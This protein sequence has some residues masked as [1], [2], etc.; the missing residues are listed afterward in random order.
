MNELSS[1]DGRHTAPHSDNSIVRTAPVETVDTANE[2]TRIII[3]PHEGDDP[4]DLSPQPTDTPSPVQ[5]PIQPPTYASDIPS[6]IPAEAYDADDIGPAAGHT[7]KEKTNLIDFSRNGTEDMVMN[8]SVRDALRTRGDSAKEVIMTE[9][10][11][12]IARRV[13]T[14]V[15]ASSL[16]PTERSHINRSSMFLKVKYLPTGAFG[17]LK[18][19]LVAGGRQ[20]DREMYDDLSAPTV[21][22]SSVFSILAVAAHEGRHIAVT[23]IGGAFLH[24]DMTTGVNVYMR[25]DRVM[26]DMLVSAER[27]YKPYVDDKGCLIV[28]LDKALYGCVES[29]AL[30]YEHL[31]GTLKSLGYETND[32]APHAPLPAALITKLR[33]GAFEGR[34]KAMQTQRADERTIWPMMWSRM[35]LA[36]Q[37]KVREEA[38]FDNAHLNL[39]CV[40]L[41][42]FSE[43]T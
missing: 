12:M 8:I 9:L 24:A 32:Y 10:K 29:A 27:K 40:R 6:D 42:S 3:T 30:W 37:C 23:D 16:T 19:R 39:D 18:A 35:S 5:H 43:R 26:T 17:K 25:L 41:Y 1:N 11:Q 36:S 14:P 38:D 28:K 33:E 4:T 20:Q 31:A 22:T 34:R 21:S 7:V 13:W 15:N 2:P